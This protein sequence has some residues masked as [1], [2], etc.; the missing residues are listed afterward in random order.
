MNTISSEIQEVIT[1]FSTKKVEFDMLN[2][3]LPFCFRTGKFPVPYFGL[4]S[5]LMARLTWNFSTDRPDRQLKRLLTNQ[6]ISKYFQSDLMRFSKNYHH[7]LVDMLIRQGHYQ[8]ALEILYIIYP[9]LY[10]SLE[11]P[12]QECYQNLSL[13]CSGMPVSCAFLLLTREYYMPIRSEFSRIPTYCKTEMDYK[14]AVKILLYSI[15]N[16]M[17][18]ADMWLCISTLFILLNHQFATIQP[19]Y[20]SNY[21]DSSSNSNDMEVENN[22]TEAYLK[23]IYSSMKA[24]LK[25]FLEKNMFQDKV[26]HLQSFLLEICPGIS[27]CQLK[28]MI[29][30]LLESGYVDF[31][32]IAY[33]DFLNSGI[34]SNSQYDATRF[35]EFSDSTVVEILQQHVPDSEKQILDPLIL[36]QIASYAGQN[37]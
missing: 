15:R 4:I 18:E 11:N 12:F 33:L 35:S 37:S 9:N 25:N 34:I 20:T 23:E 2:L 19:N 27:E 6:T 31:P 7:F 28:L 32:G 14:D 17:T 5:C 26:H 24:F 1:Q 29:E 10:Q 16:N 21:F 36:E 30:I 8:E 22:E 13:F 3:I